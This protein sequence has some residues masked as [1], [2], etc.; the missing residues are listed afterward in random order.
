MK[1]IILGE[2]QTK[3][4]QQYPYLGKSRQGRVVLFTSETCGFILEDP[5]GSYK[6]GHRS[7]GWAEEDFTPIKGQVILEND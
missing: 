2:S 5:I 1:K 7:T 6:V 3:K 4:K